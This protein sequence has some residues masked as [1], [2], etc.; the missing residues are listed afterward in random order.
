MKDYKI[1]NV[2]KALSPI[3]HIG[4]AISTTSYLVQDPIIQED[5][6]VKEV[7]CY[8]GN[9]FRGQLRDILAT[10]YAE[11][12][13]AKFDMDT[14]HLLYTGGKISGGQSINIEEA[15]EYRALFPAF[16]LL[17]GGI[18]NQI[19]AGKIKVG[20]SYPICQEARPILGAEYHEKADKISYRSLTQEKSFSRM[21]DSK[22]QEMMD[23][24]SQEM[25]TEVL[26]GKVTDEVS[27]QMRMTSELLVAGA[28]LVNEIFLTKV[29]Q[30]ELGAMLL[31]ITE[32][33]KAP[34][35]G[36]QSNKGHGKVAI[37]S[38]LV[39][40]DGAEIAIFN[41]DGSINETVQR[42]IDKYLEAL[43]SIKATFQ[44]DEK[45]AKKMGV[46]CS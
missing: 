1:K 42:R 38:Y 10:H 11:A 9:A 16:S 6:S 3:S 35:I 14:F 46:V 45:L 26:R 17:G 20:N 8:S 32:F 43:E 23:M 28:E 19:I 36:G 44:S 18:G 2:L 24:M 7:F 12:I 4:E 30:E 15:K 41:E 40:R 13:G 22:K 29:T 39:D 34:Y 25:L 31:A 27:T 5:G 21:D 37:T 33:A